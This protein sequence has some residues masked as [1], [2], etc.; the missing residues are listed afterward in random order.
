MKNCVKKVTITPGCITCGLCEF[1]A[2]A[3]FEVTDVSHV[4][5]DADLAQHTSAISE[6]AALCPVNVIKIEKESN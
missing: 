1:I 2:P 6:A 3:V 4:K 5:P